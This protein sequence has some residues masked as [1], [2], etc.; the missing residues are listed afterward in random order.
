[1][2]DWQALTQLTQGKALVVER[3]RLADSAIAI[4]GAFE[5][6]ELARL[7]RGEISADEAVA[8]LEGRT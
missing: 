3:V 5:L 4:E 6:P 8:A 2:T 1:M 7:R